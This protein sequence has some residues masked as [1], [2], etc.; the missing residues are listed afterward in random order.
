MLVALAALPQ[1]LLLAKA[2][3][4]A[5]VL[6]VQ[7]GQRCRRTETGYAHQLGCRHCCAHMLGQQYILMTPEIR[8]L[9]ALAAAATA[10]TN[11]PSMSSAAAANSWQLMNNSTAWQF[12][13]QISQGVE[14]NCVDLT[15]HGHCCPV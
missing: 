8:V 2:T 11:G 6:V 1:L 4:P 7:A 10:A 3:P 13:L 15:Q 12:S 5:A 14:Y 9:L